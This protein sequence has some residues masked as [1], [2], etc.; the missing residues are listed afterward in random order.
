VPVVPEVTR[1]DLDLA[2]EAGDWAAVGATAALLAAASDSQS[3][4]SRSRASMSRGGSSISSLD[5]ARAAEL[6]HLVDA[7]DWE[8]VV[9]AAAK[10]ESAEDQSASK[11]SASQTSRTGGGSSAFSGA[12]TTLSDSPSKT[13]KRDEIR[14][15]VENL[16]RRVVPEEIDN[17]DEMMLQF[18]GREEE[19]VETL[20]TMQER[21]VAQ[22]ARVQGQKQA[23]RDARRAAHEGGISLP[24]PPTVSAA[25][26]APAV[27][28][29]SGSLTGGISAAAAAGVSVGVAAAA[30]IAAAV[31]I[32]SSQQDESDHASSASGSS[33][34]AS[35]S[36][37]ASPSSVPSI[38]GE[39]NAK[40]DGSPISSVDEVDDLSSTKRRTALELAIEAGDWEAVGEAAAM[41]SDAS[42]NSA[43]TGEINRYAEG[44][45]SVSEHSA[46]RFQANAERAAELDE[47]I[48][49]GDWTG[50]VAAAS[51]F[52]TTEVSPP[53]RDSP[54]H[55][56]VDPSTPEGIAA[57]EKERRLRE[58]QDALA[59]ADLWMEIAQQS[60]LE[61]STGM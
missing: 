55:A 38:L 56:E 29:S 8:G 28:S 6:D 24:V 19:L 48:D 59:Q 17:V 25:A 3:V 37:F 16:V 14:E 54:T 9:V 45:G 21:L 30:G 42:V 20:R 53:A 10:F 51:R 36:F 27:F 52:G 34:D 1:E 39:Q 57:A 41:M 58:E 32:G 31:G 46:A 60:K 33:S 7:G 43:S 49:R 4:S 11:S 13:A 18:K 61:G 23:K 40:T 22:K 26:T 50:V 15:E 44:D 35:E 12:S 47:M 5:A 2:I